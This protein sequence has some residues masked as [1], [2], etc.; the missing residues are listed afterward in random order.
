MVTCQLQKI[1]VAY[2]E[3]PTSVSPSYT[4]LALPKSPIHGQEHLDF[5]LNSER[6]ERGSKS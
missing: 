2:L 6:P 5:I 3:L 1:C 4:T